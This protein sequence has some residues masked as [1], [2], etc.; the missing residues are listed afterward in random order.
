MNKP[1]SKNMFFFKAFLAGIIGSSA[2]YYYWGLNNET[3]DYMLVNFHW[4]F[5]EVIIFWFWL[6][7]EL[8]VKGWFRAGFV[9]SIIYSVTLVVAQTIAER[10]I[11]KP[12]ESLWV[13]AVFILISIAAG[14]LGAIPQWFVSRKVFEKAYQWI[15]V[16]AIG[17]GVL[18]FIY[19]LNTYSYENNILSFRQIIQNMPDV[20]WFNNLSNAFR[21]GLFGIILGIALYNFIQ[22]KSVTTAS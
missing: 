3:L 16:N 8:S 11:G 7:K 12:F 2:L 20:Q 4:Y 18:R 14:G 10:L 22:S 19:W 1:D 9:G 13:D 5:G 21:Y 6:G 15:V 17:Y